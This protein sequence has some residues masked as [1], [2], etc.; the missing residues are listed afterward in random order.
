MFS[1][2]IT[3]GPA[4]S[5]PTTLVMLWKDGDKAR[6]ARDEM[7]MLDVGPVATIADDFGQEL[8]LVTTSLISIWL[9]NMEMSAVASIERGLHQMRTQIKGT[10]AAQA[11]PIAKVAMMTGGAGGPG[12]ALLG[13]MPRA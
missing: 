1:L 10:Q 11:D 9:E 8:S 13:G 7:T 2:S 3:F 12:N 4:G 6:A 5:A